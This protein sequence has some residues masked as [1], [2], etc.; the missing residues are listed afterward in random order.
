VS[1]AGVDPRDPAANPLVCASMRMVLDVGNWD[2]NLFVLPGGQ[3]GN[4]LSPHY[5]DQLGLWSKGEGTTIPWS[6]DAVGWAMV[7]T[8]S[9]T[10]RSTT[11]VK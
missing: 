10:P 1:Q 7:S 3:S 8:L 2:E 9:L 4:P 5:D 11:V 6:A